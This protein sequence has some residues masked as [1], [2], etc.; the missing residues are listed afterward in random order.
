ML[1]RTFT[2]SQRHTF[3]ILSSFL[4]FLFISFI[5][6]IY[7]IINKFL[8]LYMGPPFGIFGGVANGD[9]HGCIRLLDSLFPIF[10]GEWRAED[11]RRRQR[12]RERQR[13]RETET[14]TETVRTPYVYTKSHCHMHRVRIARLSVRLT[15]TPHRR[16]LACRTETACSP[17]SISVC[18][19]GQGVVLRGGLAPC[20]CAACLLVRAARCHGLQVHDAR[21]A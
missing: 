6:F 14:E 3:L 4:P 5:S 20:P 12:Q 11:E 21:V 7:L 1:F 10:R 17:L 19:H 8:G 16:P 18:R 15:L 2:L 13:D 9:I